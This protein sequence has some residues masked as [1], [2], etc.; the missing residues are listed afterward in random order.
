MLT[1]TLAALT[2][3]P[4]GS[5]YW[6]YALLFG[7]GGHG[8]LYK[9]NHA[10]RLWCEVQAYKEQVKYYATDK[11]LLFAGFIAKK[12]SLNISVDEAHAL[13]LKD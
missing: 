6:Y 2:V 10:Y 11:R 12:Y 5:F 4:L 8:L 9:F 1:G 13:L 7:A 3:E